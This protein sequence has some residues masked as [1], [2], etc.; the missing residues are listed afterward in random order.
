MGLRFRVQEYSISEIF[1]AMDSIPPETNRRVNFDNG[2]TIKPQSHRLVLFRT[3][4]TVCVA[5]DLQ[6][7]HF[8]LESAEADVTP[9]LNL[10]AR[11]DGKEVMF[12]KD[13]IFPKSKGG[14]DK[15]ENYQ[16]MCKPCNSAKGALVEGENYFL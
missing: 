13:H 9:H 12:T 6:A 2:L 3:K 11:L 10:Y 16:T 4:G 14:P 1:T 15:L 7:T 5:C 8:V